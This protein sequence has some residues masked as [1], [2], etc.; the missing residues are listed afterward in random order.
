[1][2]V[3]FSYHY[4]IAIYFQVWGMSPRADILIDISTVPPSPNLIYLRRITLPFSNAPISRLEK[5]MA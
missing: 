3:I 4:H 1:M 5:D 2:R